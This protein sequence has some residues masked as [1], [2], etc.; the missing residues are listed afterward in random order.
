MRATR[1]VLV[2]A[3]RLYGRNFR[4]LLLTSGLLLVPLAV[5]QAFTG[6]LSRLTPEQFREGWSANVGSVVMGV[7]DVAVKLLTFAVVTLAVARLLEGKPVGWREVWAAGLRRVRPVLTTAL[8]AL[9]PMFGWAMLIMLPFYVLA[10]LVGEETRAA[11]A[12][13]WLANI[14]M[15]TFVSIRLAFTTAVPVIEGVGGS[16]GYRRNRRLLVDRFW[17]A[18]G[19]V[20]LVTMVYVVVS[21][22]LSALMPASTGRAAES[23]WQWLMAPLEVAVAVIL[24]RRFRAE[25]SAAQDAEVLAAED[26]LGQA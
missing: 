14:G 23:V 3:F 9:L 8:V 1:D 17:R 25:E 6:P 11:G 12:L 4:L 19:P 21:S 20:G 18:A 5:V 10:S 16:A 15:L 7:A 2:E 22:L 24:Y 13:R 26:K